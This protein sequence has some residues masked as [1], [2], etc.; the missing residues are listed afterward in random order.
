MR[1]IPCRNVSPT[2]MTNYRVADRDLLNVPRL[3]DEGLELLAIYHSHPVTAPYPSPTDAREARYPDSLYVLLSLR[4]GEP[5]IKA[6]AI[7]G[8]RVREVLTEIE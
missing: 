7:E 3:E 1:V 2:P 5:E 8:E 6:Y 4:H